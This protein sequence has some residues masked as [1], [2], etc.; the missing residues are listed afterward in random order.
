MG[1]DFKVLLQAII[2]D[3]S[4]TDIQK[5]LARKKLEITAD[6]DLDLQKFVNS[7]DH[8]EKAIKDFAE[9]IKAEFKKIDPTLDINDKQALQYAR[10]YYTQ[11]TKGAKEAVREQE[12]L[13]ESQ[14]KQNLETQE[15]YYKKIIQNNKEIFSLRNKLITSGEK[16]SEEIE[17][18]IKL[19][20]KRNKY[21]YGQLDSKGLKDNNWERTVND[22]ENVHSRQLK[23]NESHKDDLDI[24][25]Q[26]TE[27]EKRLSKETEKRLALEKKQR[28]KVVDI[29]YDLDTEKYATQINAVT[30][31]L[32]KFDSKSGA[33]FTEAKQSADALRVSY[34]ALQNAM[35]DP[36]LSN[37]NKIAAEEAYQ[38]ALAK[39]QNLLRQLNSNTDNKI[40]QVGDTQRVNLIATLSKY[41][42]NNTAMTRENQKVIERW[43][44][45]LSSSDDMTVGAI[46]NINNEFKKL[47]AQLR[48]TGQ[49]G[50]STVDK[51]KNAW[52]K[53]GGWSIATGSI[54]AVYNQLRKIPQEVLKVDS[55]L[56]E[57][58]KVSNES[59][60]TIRAYFD[61]ASE[62]AKELGAT[63]SDV[64]N[65]TA[66]W[67]R[68][69]YNLPDAAELARVATVYKNV[70]DGISM[71]DATS[72]IISTLKAKNCLVIQ[73]CVTRTYLIAGKA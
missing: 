49:L 33:V 38:K 64:I 37:A 47:D 20:E 18:Q 46:K 7:T 55:A 56:V 70:G 59:G 29:Q 66:D 58:N 67:A 32:S 31:Q 1:E 72:S 22:L 35:N 4:L 36:T 51:F 40:V 12:K 23:I 50:L 3:S 54:M 9:K 19:L 8:A 41:L 63:I 17:R 69:G 43:I 62:T 14:K 28:D 52:E 68:L 53:F 71:E 11:V 10:Q 44:A 27:E 60:A 15:K 39:T 13:N 57:L 5:Q 61:D 16:E 24:K 34:D 25:K 6:I 42:E 21:N 65:S 2:D 26:L 73:K 30:T 45:T 48:S